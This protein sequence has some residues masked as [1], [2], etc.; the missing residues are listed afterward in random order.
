MI[1]QAAILKDVRR[2]MPDILHETLLIVQKI[3]RSFVEEHNLRECSREEDLCSRCY[4]TFCVQDFW[5][6]LNHPLLFR[7]AI[8]LIHSIL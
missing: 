6:L 1:S 8:L 3:K 5:P 7:A 4:E 2:P